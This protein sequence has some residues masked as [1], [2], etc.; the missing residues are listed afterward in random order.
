MNSSTDSDTAPLSPMNHA[1]GL[2]PPAG[3]AMAP[4]EFIRVI[5]RLPK[6]FRFDV[7]PCAFE[8][9][10]DSWTRIVGIHHEVERQVI[11]ISDRW[12]YGVADR[13]ELPK[14]IGGQA[15]GGDC[16]DKCLL[17]HKRLT[18]AGI[19]EGALRLALCMT[20]SGEA[21]A[22]LL[23]EVGAPDGGHWVLDNR[24]RPALPWHSTSYCRAAEGHGRWIARS[25]PGSFWWETLDV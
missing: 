1:A 16:E 3:M 10:V 12:Q 6:M 5:K 14:S 21:H 7:V 22:V 2:M 13:W 11:H 20:E 23:I 24:R 18:A 25:V 4:M 9:D 17:K 8:V 19:P 15:L